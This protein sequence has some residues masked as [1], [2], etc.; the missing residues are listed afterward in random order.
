MV[1]A[2]RRGGRRPS[3]RFLPIKNGPVVLFG[4]FL[5]L[6]KFNLAEFS[7]GTVLGDF[8]GKNSIFSPCLCFSLN[9]ISAHIFVFIQCLKIK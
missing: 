7:G 4:S 3:R 1:V 5:H 2:G 9:T 8:N 6:S